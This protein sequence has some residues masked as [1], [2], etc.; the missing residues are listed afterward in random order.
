MQQHRFVQVKVK[1]T[2][3]NE[4]NGNEQPQHG[5]KER[6]GVPP[7][8]ELI[9]NF[10]G[11]AASSGK[12]KAVAEIFEAKS[13]IGSPGSSTPK[14]FLYNPEENHYVQ[15]SDS[16]RAE[17]SVGQQVGPAPS[18]ADL[19]RKG[20]TWREP[21]A[22]GPGDPWTALGRHQA[23]LEN[24]NT[25]LRVHRNAIA[26]GHAGILKNS[27]E[28]GRLKENNEDIQAKIA[29]IKASQP[30]GWKSKA[31]NLFA[32]TALG[33]ASTVAVTSALHDK[34]QSK[35]LKAQSDNI[36]QLQSEV[37]KL[38]GLQGQQVP[39][40]VNGPS[41]AGQGAPAIDGGFRAAGV[42]EGLV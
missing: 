30:G 1:R 4:T 20:V 7:V 11:A 9:E 19:A 21:V 24:H 15:S 5:T 18:P 10:E 36:R 17:T 31:K 3:P 23:V 33:T 25:D 37:A 34:G 12:G 26:D 32:W 8:G 28:I 41:A 42:G 2:I 35:D 27:E 22:A 39:T 38:K 14:T 16:V 29:R 40:Y 6:R 13:H